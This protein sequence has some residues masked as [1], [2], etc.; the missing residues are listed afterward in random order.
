MQERAQLSSYEE[1]NSEGRRALGASRITVAALVLIEAAL[2]S[3]TG[4][5]ISEVVAGS[6]LLSLDDPMPSLTFMAGIAVLAVFVGVIAITIP[7]LFAAHREPI[8]ELRVP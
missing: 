8:V 5:L 7:A 4:A 6:L 2:V 1:K 3:A